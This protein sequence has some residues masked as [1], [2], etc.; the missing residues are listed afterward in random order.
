MMRNDMYETWKRSVAKG[1]TWFLIRFSMLFGIALLFTNDFAFAGLFSIAYYSAGS[2]AYII[3]ERFW[4]ISSFGEV[5][6]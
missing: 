1:T 5:A 6:K 4:N 3:H 2:V